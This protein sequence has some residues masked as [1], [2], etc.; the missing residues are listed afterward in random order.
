MNRY[1]RGFRWVALLLVLSLILTACGAPD[2]K[3]GQ[4]GGKKVTLMLDWVPNTN[5][6]GLYVAQEKGYFADE[7]LNV[8]IA[9]PA[10]T[11]ANQLVGAG[12]AD[13]GISSQEYVIQ[14]RAQGVPIVSIAAILQHNT[15]GF[16]AP[17]EKGIKRARDFVG[18]TYGGWGTPIENAFIQTVLQMDG[19]K[20]KQ[21]EDKVKIVN[22]GE[23]DFF[24]AT[25]RNVDFA[26]IYYGWTGIQAETQGVVLD[27]LELR[28]L[29]PVLDFYTPTLITNEQMIQK[30]P[31]TVKKLVQA[32]SRGYRYAI[33]HPEEAADILV[34][35]APETDKKLARASQKWMSPRY[36]AEAARWGEQKEK[37]WVDFSDWMWKHRLMEKKVDATKAYTNEFLPEK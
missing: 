26:W 36:Q 32:V 12:K 14:G 5:H 30:D 19:V 15:S 24:A 25:K 22:M 23:T 33:S 1:R 8:E 9:T 31:E 3:D 37:V 21:V 2:E 13:F 18:K 34:K 6:T 11:S 10:E 20:T 27:F 17:K 28:K 35:A 16:A 4:A 7:G 29:D